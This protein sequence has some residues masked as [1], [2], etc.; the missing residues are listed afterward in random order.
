MKIIDKKNLI[1]DNNVLIKITKEHPSGRDLYSNINTLTIELS[2]SNSEKIDFNINTKDVTL[3]VFENTASK[4]NFESILYHEF[5]HIADRLDPK[6]KYSD[7]KKDAL[8]EDE[9]RCV[10]ELW[11]LYI[12]A[13]LNN[14]GLFV[15]QKGSSILKIDGKYQIFHNK[16]IEVMLMNTINF[17]RTRGVNEVEQIVR[18]IWNC[19]NHYMSYGDMLS[20]IKKSK[21]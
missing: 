6:F 3:Y 8:P 15:T 13:R 21:L 14:K 12:N 16:T 10:M 11:N 5:F 1:S 17:L 9:K 19:S 7:K 2:T 18:E 20:I 4:D